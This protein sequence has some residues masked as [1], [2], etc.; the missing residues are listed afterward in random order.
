MT[1]LFKNVKQILFV[2]FNCDDI[3][4]LIFS[5]HNERKNVCQKLV[6]SQQITKKLC[7]SDLWQMRIFHMRV[8]LKKEINHD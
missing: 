2:R 5:I 7:L 6:D 4:N 3:I 1:H 8:R